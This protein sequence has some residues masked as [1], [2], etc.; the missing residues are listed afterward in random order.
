M[1]SSLEP[2]C[3]AWAELGDGIGREQSGRRP[4]IVIS[5]RDHLL[6]ADGLMTVVPATTAK[7]D[8]PNHVPLR[9]ETGLKR[10]TF[11]MT[12]QAVTIS[13]ERLVRGAGAVDRACLAEI[14]QWVDD[15]LHLPGRREGPGRSPI[16]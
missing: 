13:R 7:R 15:W 2:G 5:S 3:V 11:A 1:I 6:L 4:V 12:E 16:R 8:W 14:M 9:G 10:P